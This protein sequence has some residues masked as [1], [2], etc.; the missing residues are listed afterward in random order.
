[1]LFLLFLQE[2]IS[3]RSRLIRRNPGDRA[4]RRAKE[5]RSEQSRR[6]S[7]TPAANR[8]LE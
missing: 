5:Q 1:L 4:M 7:G 3:G 2:I 8:V 6:G